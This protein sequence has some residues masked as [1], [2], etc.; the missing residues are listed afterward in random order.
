MFFLNQWHLD[1]THCLDICFWGLK[2]DQDA[3]TE[4]KPWRCVNINAS[5]AEM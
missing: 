2:Q 4:F 1:L 5:S 3:E